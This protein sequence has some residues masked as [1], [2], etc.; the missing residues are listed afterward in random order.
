MRGL[1][2]AAEGRVGATGGRASFITTTSIEQASSRETAG[3]RYETPARR[4]RSVQARAK[5][6]SSPSK[7]S[8]PETST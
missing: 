2:D 5:T 1:G 3:S 6:F 4:M 8:M 7:A